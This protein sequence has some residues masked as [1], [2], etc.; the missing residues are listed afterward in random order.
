MNFTN[1][2]SSSV[3]SMQTNNNKNKTVTMDPSV[4]V[5]VD[6]GGMTSSPASRLRPQS[7]RL[8]MDGT[9]LTER[10]FRTSATPRSARRHYPLLTAEAL[11]LPPESTFST[12]RT[13]RTTKSMRSRKGT[14]GTLATARGGV[15][16][17]PTPGSTVVI[18]NGSYMVRAGFSSD[19]FP[20]S[21]FPSAVAVTEPPS[22]HASINSK[23]DACY[24]VGQK[25][26]HQVD[27]RRPYQSGQVT[28]WEDMEAIWEHAFSDCLQIDTTSSKVFLTEAHMPPKATRERTLESMFEL[29]NV[30]ATYLHV[31]PVLALFSAGLTS[32]CV[33]DAGEFSTTVYPV[34]DGYHLTNASKKLKFGGIDIC[35]I[36]EN[37]ILAQNEDVY[38]DDLLR[39]LSD[40]VNDPIRNIKETYC[41][42]KHLTSSI[43]QDDGTT[44]E[45]ATHTHTKNVTYSLPD[46]T[47]I[48]INTVDISTST[49]RFFDSTMFGDICEPE[50]FSVPQ[51]VHKCIMSAGMDLRRSL[52]SAV[53]LTGGNSMFAGFPERLTS[54]LKSLFPGN[55]STSLKVMAPPDRCNAVWNGG[56]ILTSLS[57]FEDQWITGA[58][59]DEY[60]AEIV[61]RKCTVYL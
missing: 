44:N 47:S 28:E 29:F 9:P 58:D 10:S 26:L 7:R 27:M 4:V 43:N 19:D 59:Y 18:D 12:P 53:V 61:H 5:V 51:T 56:S 48:R 41:R 55:M 16:S 21:I 8:S 23:E 1:T 24:F 11:G 33:I 22:E 38:S 6:D 34:A 36:V 54:E 3:S 35:D 60:G 15:S 37:K 52:L 45:T 25:A 32:G 20:R 42:V 40:P 39:F 46:G 49:E 17:M 14:L 13:A 57:T 31:Q 50:E 30:E 2:I